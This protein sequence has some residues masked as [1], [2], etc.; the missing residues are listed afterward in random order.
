LE[1]TFK[2]NGCQRMDYEPIVAGGVNA[3]CLHYVLNNQVLNDGELLLI[4]A[5]GLHYG[6]KRT[7]D[8][9]KYHEG[10]RILGLQI[11]GENPDL[12]C[13]AAKYVEKIGGDFVDLNLGCPVP[14]VVKKG[15]GT[16]MCRDVVKLEKILKQLVNSTR[17]P[18]TI[19][20]RTGWDEKSKNIHEVIKAATNAGVMWVSIHGR[21]RAQQYT[22]SSDWELIGQAKIKSKIPIIGNGDVLTPQQAVSNYKTYGVDAVMIGRG[23]LKNPFIFEQSAKLLKGESYD[24]PS[25]QRYFKL[26]ERKKK[27][28]EEH[29]NEDRALLHSKKF[30]AWFAAGFEGASAFR[31]QVFSCQEPKELWD[32]AHGF[33]WVWSLQ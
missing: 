15:A 23:A 25:E 13:N 5:N 29:F 28:F 11:F 33:F 12:L 10:E 6:G 19:K 30:I 4:S 1:F 14:K 2:K 16:A 21:T 24:L 9:F 7:L 18:V 32:K 27:Y 26:M 22:G 20:I 3:T 31:K 17:I 8:M